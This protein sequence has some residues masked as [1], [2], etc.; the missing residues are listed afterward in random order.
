MQTQIDELNIKLNNLSIN[1]KNQY[2]GKTLLHEIKM[3]YVNLFFHDIYNT[4]FYILKNVAFFKKKT[5][6]YYYFVLH[7]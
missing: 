7:F 6:I 4:S 1:N 3:Y 2:L 5:C